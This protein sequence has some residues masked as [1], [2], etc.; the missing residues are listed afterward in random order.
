M[1]QILQTE[2]LTGLQCALTRRPHFS[3]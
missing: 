1:D 3:A 2:L